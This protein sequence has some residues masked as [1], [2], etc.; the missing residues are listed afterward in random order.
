MQRNGISSESLILA[1]AETGIA[2]LK[3]VTPEP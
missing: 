3:A 1:V 2:E